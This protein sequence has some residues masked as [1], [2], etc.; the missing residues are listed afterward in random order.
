MA[1]Q[2]KKDKKSV[3]QRISRLILGKERPNFITQ[4]SVILGFLIWVYLLAW[5]VLT[6]MAIILMDTLK[7]ADRL[8]GAFMRVGSKL[9]GYENTINRLTVYTLAEFI[10]FTVVLIGL[11]L[12]WRRK[13]VGFLIY[14]FGNVCIPLTTIVVLGFDYFRLET[15][16]FDLILYG[17]TTLYFG[18]GA[19]WLYKW[20]NKNEKSQENEVRAADSE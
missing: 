2:S 15:P 16:T 13:K 3:L 5:H 14:V 7:Q 10:V 8:E 12:I 6:F 20:K 18:L 4:V 1:K 19:M 11:I 17:A 9:Y